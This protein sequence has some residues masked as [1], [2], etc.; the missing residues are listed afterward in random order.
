MTATIGFRARQACTIARVE[1]RRAFFS[2][3]SVWVYLLALLPAAIFLAHGIEAK[4]DRQRLSAKG[5]TPAALLD[6]I[7]RGETDEAVRA[8]LGTPVSEGKFEHRRR[9]LRE[10]SGKGTEPRVWEEKREQRRRLTYSDGRRRADLWF[11]NGVLREKSIHLLLNFE[12]DRQV[13]AGLFQYFYL[14]LAIFFGC[15]GIFMN[16]FRGEMLDKTLHFWFLAPI[17]R[18]VLLAGKYAAGLAA[19]VVIFTGGALLCFA[20]MLWP[21]DPGEVQVYWQASGLSHAFW[22]A[23]AAALGCVGYGSV[24]LA[25]GLLLRNPIVPAAA[26]LLWEAINGFLPATLEKISVLYYLQSL[27][28]VPAPVDNGAPAIIRML[29]SPGEPASRFWSVAGLLALTAVVLVVAAR[30]S[31]RIQISYS[32]E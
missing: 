26:L 30:A 22:Y 23:A 27:C 29:L 11:E 32:T 5:L 7:K 21:H 18:E 17:R 15:L 20:A 16:L 31:R 10:G 3:R 12:E 28:P 19:A 9:V 1:L 13:F 2:K 4:I 24:F 6:G 14:R 8:R 25:I